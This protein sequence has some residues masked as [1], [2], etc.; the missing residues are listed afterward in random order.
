MSIFTSFFLSVLASVVAYYI[1]KWLDGDKQLVVSLGLKPPTRNGIKKP[2]RSRLWGF[3]LLAMSTHIFLP[4]GIIAYAFRHFKYT[5]LPSLVSLSPYSLS[6]FL[7]PL[8]NK[9][10]I[11]RCTAALQIAGKASNY[12]HF[13]SGAPTLF[14]QFK[15]CIFPETSTKSLNIT[16]FIMVQMPFYNRTLGGTAHR[17]MGSRCSRPG[18]KERCHR[19][20]SKACG[21]KQPELLMA[22]FRLSQLRFS[23]IARP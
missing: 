2:Q 19:L 11:G 23:L 16:N 8:Q 18:S 17:P 4:T 22:A 5:L 13:N 14:L 6:Q 1:C 7:M 20:R 3:L 15:W 9:A 12:K 21:G 10:G